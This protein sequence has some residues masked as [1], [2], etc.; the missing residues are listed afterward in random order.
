MFDSVSSARSVAGDTFSPTTSGW[1]TEPGSTEPGFSSTIS[2]YVAV[3]S[4]ALAVVPSSVGGRDVL[5][6]GTLSLLPKLTSSTISVPIS[7]LPTGGSSGANA[8]GG[9]DGTDLFPPP[10][11]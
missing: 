10:S 4:I 7:S 8:L 6:S 1:S 11:H 3:K 9:N 2:R 5:D